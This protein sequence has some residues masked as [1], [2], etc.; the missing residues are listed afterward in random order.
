MRHLSNLSCSA[1]ENVVYVPNVAP[2]GTRAVVL[3]MMTSETHS[4][5]MRETGA[6]HSTVMQAVAQKIYLPSL[7]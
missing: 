7:E 1:Y 4:R 2:R 5:L 3:H 6:S